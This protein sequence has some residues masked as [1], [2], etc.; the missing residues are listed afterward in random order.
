MTT[1]APAALRPTEAQN[2]L[3][4]SS[5]CHLLF[6]YRLLRLTLAHYMG[7]LTISWGDLLGKK[8]IDELHSRGAPI[9]KET[10]TEVE[11][12]FS[13]PYTI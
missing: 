2:L 8:L 13:R 6:S 11:M 12:E 4:T 3:V 5:S 1:L 10:E 9:G 7:L